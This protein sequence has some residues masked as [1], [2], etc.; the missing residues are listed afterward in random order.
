MPLT[1]RIA[2]QASSATA[3]N[4]IARA[5]R[6]TMPVCKRRAC[7]PSQPVTPASPFTAPSMPRW[8]G[9]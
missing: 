5:Y 2:S 6:P 1:Y 7:V 8:S 3:P 4:S 9:S